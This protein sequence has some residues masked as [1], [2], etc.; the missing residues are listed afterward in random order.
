M[1]GVHPTH[2]MANGSGAEPNLDAQAQ[3][4][5]ADCKMRVRLVADR[6]K[7]GEKS[8]PQL[9]QRLVRWQLCA[10]HIPPRHKSS[11]AA[12]VVAGALSQVGQR[13]PRKGASHD[14][15]VAPC[16]GL[17]QL[18]Y[19]RARQ[20]HWQHCAQTHGSKTKSIRVTLSQGVCL[21]PGGVLRTFHEAS[22][23]A[24]Q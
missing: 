4:S 17:H 2:W 19:A 21:V 5:C 15:R 9:L 16:G 3:T 12:P 7:S 11:S 8:D 6:A 23:T 18:R 24:W 22:N 13:E 1:I 10:E 14:M 20:V